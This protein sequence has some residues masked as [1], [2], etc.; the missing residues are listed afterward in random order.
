[1]KESPQDVITLHQQVE[2]QKTEIDQ[3]RRENDQKSQEINQLKIENDQH[4]RQKDAHIGQ[5]KFEVDQL[6]QQLVSVICFV[7]ITIYG[8]AILVLHK[9]CTNTTSSQSTQQSNFR[10]TNYKDIKIENSK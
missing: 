10:R 7:I 5:L 9:E 1:M 8:I 3:L 6:N 2:Q 4:K